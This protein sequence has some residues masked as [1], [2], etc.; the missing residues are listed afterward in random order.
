MEYQLFIQNQGKNK[1]GKEQVKLL[2]KF[3]QLEKFSPDQGKI[4]GVAVPYN[5]KTSDYRMI[6]FKPGAFK[7]IKR[8]PC[9]INHEAW[10]VRS[11]VGA[12]NFTDTSSALMFEAALNM[13][14]DMVTKK[15]IPLIDMGA[16]EG[17]S[18]GCYILAK[19]DIYDQTT[20]ERVE[21]KITDAEI[22][23]LSLVTF[24]AFEDA[25]IKLSKE[26]EMDKINLNQE[27]QP[28]QENKEEN[29]PE[30]NKPEEN[31]PE[32]NE[33]VEEVVPEAAPDQIEEK[34]VE[35]NQPEENEVEEEVI[36]EAAPEQVE[37]KPEE[38]MSNSEIENLKKINA[39]KDNEILQ[40]KNQINESAKKAAVEEL[41]K[42]GV[43]YKSQFER[44][45]KA[46]SNAEAINEFYKGIPAAFS[47]EP[48]GSNA[49]DVVQDIK[50]E[51]YR[52]LAKETS[53]KEEDFEK[54]NN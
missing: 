53:L 20:K 44:I 6:S 40:L 18:I 22:Y 4:G 31:K 8:V 45:M 32:E 13:L 35:E 54:Y 47:V 36:P 43:V 34:P 38:K 51:K 21:T 33:V 1:K 3:S 11:M 12:V 9:F 15:I 29:K 10:D 52:K 49:E 39:D 50:K 23:E 46:F 19:E 24:Q 5:Q 27:A 7:N 37:N 2:F 14:D 28:E 17:V 42:N 30:E 48:K 25:K 41:I 16:L 26:C